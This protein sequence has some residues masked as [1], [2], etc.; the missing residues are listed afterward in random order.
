LGEGLFDDFFFAL[1]NLQNGRGEDPEKV[2]FWDLQGLH[3]R[4]GKGNTHKR[5]N[6][7]YSISN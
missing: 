7:K 6:A 4:I 2:L 5:I 3:I 1:F